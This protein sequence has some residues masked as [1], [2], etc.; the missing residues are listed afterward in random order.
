MSTRMFVCFKKI[1]V[2]IFD[3]STPGS[4][5]REVFRGNERCCTAAGL[6]PGSKYQLRVA[7]CNEEGGQGEVCPCV[8]FM[9]PVMLFDGAGHWKLC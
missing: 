8:I 9:K 7:A 3:C 1:S 2:S 5:Y 4:D 6:E